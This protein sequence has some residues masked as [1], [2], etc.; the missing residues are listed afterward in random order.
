MNRRRKTI[1]L[2]CFTILIIFAVFAGGAI[3]PE[4][5]LKADFAVKN[6]APSLNHIFGTDWV[7]RD[8]FLRTIK[9]MSTSIMIGMASSI[10]NVIIAVLLGTL[11]GTLS[12]YTDNVVCWLID[13]VMGIPH[14]VLLMLISFALGRGFKGV[15]IGI[16]ITHWTSLARI[17][18]GEVIQIKNEQYIKISRKMGKSSFYIMKNHIIPFVFPQAIVGGILLFPHAILHEASITFLGFGLSPES[19]AIGIILS[20]SMKYILTG[21]WWLAFFPG[22]ML[23]IIVILFDILGENIKSLIDPYTSQE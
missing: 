22:L 14:I 3:I 23:V 4:T 20:E 15:F 11:A 16:A 17:V 19:P 12:K 10:I 1:F 5:A 9:G 21:Y 13:F 8:M 2:I 6:T 7:G 18:R